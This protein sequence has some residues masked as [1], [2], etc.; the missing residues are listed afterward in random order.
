MEI[1]YALLNLPDTPAR[2]EG[3][4]VLRD[5]CIQVAQGDFWGKTSRALEMVKYV[6]VELGDWPE[7]LPEPETFPEVDGQFLPPP[8]PMPLPTPEAPSE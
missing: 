5:A 6:R 3:L 7:G 8:P 2:Q 4:G 1:L